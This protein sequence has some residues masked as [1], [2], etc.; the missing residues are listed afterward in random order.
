M[1]LIKTGKVDATVG[2]LWKSIV[3][4]MIP[5]ILGTLV[6]TC[7]NAVDLIVLGNLADSEA[8]ASVGATS[9]IIAL[10]VNSFI[11]IA[12]GTKIVL[13]RLFGAKDHVKIKQ[14]VDTSM[15]TAVALGMIMVGIGVPFA[16][17]FL[18]MTNCPEEC[19][20]GAVY[21]IRIY[22]AASPAILLYNFG[23]ATL[24]ASGDSGRPFYYIVISG[25]VN[26]V[27]NVIL[28]LV[29]ETKV[30]A[31]AVATAA[32]QVVG[33]CL[34]I[35]RLCVMEGDG[36]M[37]P[38]TLRF[39]YGSFA[40]M[41]MQGLPLV[42]NNALYPFSN[43]QIQS[44]VNT[45]GV[46][47]IAGN[48]AGGTL[49]NIPASISGSFGSAVT[50]FMGQNLGA[51]KKERVKKSFAYCLIATV[52]ISLVLTAFIYSTKRFWLSL[53]LPGDPEAV[54]F[55]IIRMTFVLLFYSVN[56]A[57]NAI[58]AAIQVHGYA[59]YTSFASIMCI[60]VFR[61]IWMWCIYPLFN[62]FEMLMACFLVTW[63]MLL[64]FN[65]IG[66]LIFCRKDRYFGAK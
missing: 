34:V 16:P 54:E 14:L 3:A 30:L 40:K 47:A 29:L 24:S 23:A 46:S 31:V 9:M 44:A 39:H 35:R 19:F 12:S 21:Y 50:V 66:Y 17:N 38:R 1:A 27:L 11:G 15:I 7:F 57:N 42:L 26:V 58:S 49:D 8:V 25:L 13:A 64:V 65:I 52:T 61:M 4:Y 2:P 32:S 22:L 28:C 41:M 10:V 63:L 33:A 55:A 37:E 51:A 59:V 60:C 45:F 6:Q 5:L 18:R 53:F 48:T 56:C 20:E 43:L 62:T 36:R